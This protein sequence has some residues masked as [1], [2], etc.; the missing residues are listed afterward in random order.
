MYSH[1]IPLPP[2]T[3]ARFCCS[4]NAIES[5]LEEDY[6]INEDSI[7]PDYVIALRITHA[8]IAA[9]LASLSEALQLSTKTGGSNLNSVAALCH[10]ATHD[11]DKMRRHLRE[12]LR[13]SQLAYWDGLISATDES[14]VT[15]WS[16]PQVCG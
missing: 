8:T 11:W 4:L 13:V 1:P 12:G 9:C 10:G 7:K 6:V 14:P 5:V 2:P 16:L 3:D 15:A